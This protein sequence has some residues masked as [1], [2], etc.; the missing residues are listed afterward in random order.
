MYTVYMHTAPSGKRY[1]GI[2]CQTVEQRWRNGKGYKTNQPFYNAIQKYGWNNI[3]HEIIEENLMHDEACE[4]ERKLIAKYDT[5]NK[6]KGYNVC[7]GGEDGWVGV[8]HTE[9]AKRKMSEAKKG[10]TY[11][12]GCHLSEETKKKLS[13]SHKGKYRGVPVPPRQYD[14]ND[15]IIFSDEH[16]R[17]I[18]QALKGIERSDEVRKRMSEAQVK[19]KKPVRC[20][21]TGE[22]FESETMAMKSLGIDK[23]LIGRACKG[24]QKTAKGLRF[25]YV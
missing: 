13:E 24:K 7:F 25:E 8:H 6:Q 17:K 16:K 2:T 11:R 1:I 15:K 21:D 23:C 5:T 19:T 18:S 3:K 20:I 14:K 12:K 10:K 9:E 4:L 22:V